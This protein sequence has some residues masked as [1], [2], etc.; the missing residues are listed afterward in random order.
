MAPVASP[1]CTASP[2]AY[3]ALKGG[4]IHMT[5]HLAAYYASDNVR[6]NCL[7]P[8]IEYGSRTHNL[9]R[10]SFLKSLKIKNSRLK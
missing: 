8:G 10:M 6:V 1:R 5:R 4:T 3:H 7:S 2:V 9:V